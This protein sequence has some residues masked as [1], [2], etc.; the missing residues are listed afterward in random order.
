MLDR[1]MDA[2]VSSN[3]DKELLNARIEQVSSDIILAK[4]KFKVAN[5]AT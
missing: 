4:N 5:F 2:G 3:S 1:R